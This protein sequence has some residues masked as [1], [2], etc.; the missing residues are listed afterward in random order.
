MRINYFNLNCYPNLYFN[1]MDWNY[2]IRVTTILI[3]YGNYW[4]GVLKDMMKFF[5]NKQFTISDIFSAKSNVVINNY[6]F[7]EIYVN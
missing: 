2:I 4:C 1:N 3:D 5:K 6:Q 7:I